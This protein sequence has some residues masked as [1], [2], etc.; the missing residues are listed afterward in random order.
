MSD[1]G[2]RLKVVVGMLVECFDD[3]EKLSRHLGSESC[4]KV[5]DRRHMVG[6]GIRDIVP[7]LPTYLQALEWLA[8]AQSDRERASTAY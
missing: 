5:S 2:G 4:V 8:W 7:L 1:E 3:L 6:D